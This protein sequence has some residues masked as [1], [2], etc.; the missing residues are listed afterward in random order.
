MGACHVTT[1]ATGATRPAQVDEWLVYEGPAT[2]LHPWDVRS[3]VDAGFKFVEMEAQQRQRGAGGRSK[4]S[5]AT[6]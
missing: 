3:I 1:Y 2:P 5:T 6:V 4:T